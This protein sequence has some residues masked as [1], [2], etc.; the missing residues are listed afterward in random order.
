MDALNDGTQPIQGDQAGG[1]TLPRLLKLAV[2]GGVNEAIQAHLARGISVDV[3]DGQGRSPLMIAAAQG[4]ATTCRLLLDKGASLELC[5]YAGDNAITIARRGGRADALQVLE[6]AAQITIPS[7]LLPEIAPETGE[8]NGTDN[9]DWI[10]DV[11]SPPPPEDALQVAAQLEIHARINEHTPIDNDE[12]W[13]DVPLEDLLPGHGRWV[14]TL[15]GD[16][17][18]LWAVEDALRSAI[19]GGWI[20]RQDLDALTA[21]NYD[22]DGNDVLGAQIECVLHDLGVAVVDLEGYADGDPVANDDQDLIDEALDLLRDMASTT[23]DLFYL[24]LGKASRYRLLSRHDE[25]E[26]FDRAAKALEA[27]VNTLAGSWPALSYLVISAEWARTSV[28]AVETPETETAGSDK[29]GEATE[30]VDDA[31]EAEVEQDTDLSIDAVS[32][33]SSQIWADPRKAASLEELGRIVRQPGVKNESPAHILS[34]LKSLD[35]TWDVMVALDRISEQK[36]PVYSAAVD[37]VHA[38]YMEAVNSNLRLVISVARRH[39]NRGL[40]VMD[41]IQEGNLGLMKAVTRFEI[42][43]GFKLSTYA[44]WW[45][46]QSITRAIADKARPVRIPVHRLE[47]VN[48]VGKRRHLFFQEHG[49]WPT[50]EDLSPI[51]EIPAGEITKAMKADMD[52]VSLGDGED[53]S[54]PQEALVDP[55]P[56]DSLERAI[57]LNLRAIVRDMLA[58]LEPRDRRVMELRFGLEGNEEHTLEEVGQMYKVTRERIRQIEAKTLDKLGHPKRIARLRRWYS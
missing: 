27:L 55:A 17:D 5:D 11:D 35:L 10:A 49:R 53:G 39:M 38:I 29:Q 43:R 45:I 19:A 9:D 56:V 41:L 6:S 3:R 8:Q 25:A 33:W 57:Q 47:V 48:R 16:P 36:D 54:Y 52:S 40:D 31:E 1:D 18:L 32:S 23:T 42:G 34:L 20:Y 12:S 30:P 4:H 2:I 37:R 51:L 22:E 21:D 46:K 15:D 13:H 14:R 44:M 26:L 50:A 7:A 28:A 58:E 24:Y